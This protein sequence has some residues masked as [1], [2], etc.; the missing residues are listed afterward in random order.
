MN[1]W[2]ASL[3]LGHN[4]H[5]IWDNRPLVHVYTDASTLAGRT[6][7]HGDWLYRV[8]QRDRPASAHTH[9][10]PKELQMI[11]EAINHRAIQ[12]NNHC[13]RI[14]T[15]NMAAVYVVNKGSAKH[16][17]V[18]DT[19]HLIWLM[20]MK[21]NFNV[22]TVYTPGRDNDIT[23]AISWL[24]MPGQIPRFFALLYKF[25][26][27]TR[28]FWMVKHMSLNTMYFLHLQVQRWIDVLQN[29]TKKQRYGGLKALPTLRNL[30]LHRSLNYTSLSAET[31][32]TSPSQRPVRTCAGMQPI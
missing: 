7:C 8:W 31:W 3:E 23:D 11:G 13:V 18:M 15:D 22:E 30:Q 26:Y 5:L 20:S 14:H 19:L 9:I 2:L 6:F 17:L 32:D 4:K 1:W 27:F 12:F 29:W 16:P 21:H 25:N 24:H 28:G 10:N